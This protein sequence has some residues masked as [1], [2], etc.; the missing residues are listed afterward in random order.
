ML[1][2]RW[3]LLRSR[4]RSQGHGSGPPDLSS[5]FFCTVRSG[6]DDNI[7][8]YGIALCWR[9]CL[10]R[11]IKIGKCSNSLPCCLKAFE[12]HFLNPSGVKS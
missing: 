11:E 1:V 6:I 10:S 4:F 5:S 7:C 3:I 2:L 12:I 9:Q 8:D